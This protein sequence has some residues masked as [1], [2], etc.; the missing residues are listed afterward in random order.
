MRFLLPEGENAVSYCLSSP[1]VRVAWGQL[2]GVASVPAVLR[3]VSSAGKGGRGSCWGKKGWKKSGVGFWFLCVTQTRY[4]VR[5]T[6]WSVGG[7][8]PI[9]PCLGL[10]R[11]GSGSATPLCPRGAPG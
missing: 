4:R 2:E 5:V 8:V 10:F 7:V 3:E 1:W 6:G 11:V 9:T